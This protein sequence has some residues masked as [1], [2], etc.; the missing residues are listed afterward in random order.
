MLK[1]QKALAV[2]KDLRELTFT[3]DT[4]VLDHPD[5]K[6][7]IWVANGFWF[8]SLWTINGA[9]VTDKSI[10]KFGAIGKIIVWLHCLHH[11][12]RIAKIEREKAKQQEK[13]VIDFIKANQ[14]MNK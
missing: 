10:S 7:Q 12:A 3:G 11:S 9:L 2:A 8:I 4:Y 14:D 5:G 13:S 6:Y 1:L